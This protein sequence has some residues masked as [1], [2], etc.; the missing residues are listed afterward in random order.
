MNKLL[1]I[2]LVIF[3]TSSCEPRTQPSQSTAWT[4]LTSMPTARSENAAAAV[5]H[6]IYVSGGFGGEQKFEA[7][8]TRTNTW[9]TLADLP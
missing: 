1:V 4:Q 7:Y 8:D 9:Q 5:D 6:L 2:L 3:I